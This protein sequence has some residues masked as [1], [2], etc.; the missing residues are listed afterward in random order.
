MKESSRGQTKNTKYKKYITKM[1]VYYFKDL[2]RLKYLFAHGCMRK[3]I[4]HI[5]EEN[6]KLD[7]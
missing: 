7:V 4:F 2:C 3:D 1:N 5:K 6:K